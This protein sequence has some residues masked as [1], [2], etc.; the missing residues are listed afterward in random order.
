MEDAAGVLQRSVPLGLI[1]EL[2]LVG[3]VGWTPAVC[4]KLVEEGVPIVVCDR[5]G[6]ALGRFD[7]TARTAVPDRQRQ[8]RLAGDAERRVKWAREIVCG[9]IEAQRSVM[10]RIERRH[11]LVPR[12]VELERLLHATRVVE[13]LDSLRGVEGAA[14]ALYFRLRRQT[15]SRGATFAARNRDQRDVVNMSLNYVSALL[16]EKVRLAVVAA[17]L[18][19]TIGVLHESYRSRDSLVF[20]L[21]EPWR[22]Q[23]LDAT[24]FGLVGLGVLSDDSVEGEGIEAWLSVEARKRL[25]E[26]FLWRLDTLRP[27]ATGYQTSSNIF[28]RQARAFRRSLRLNAPDEIRRPH[29]RPSM[30]VLGDITGE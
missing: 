10:R 25:A 17:G 3:S 18:D 15:L 11:E 14:S 22:P 16:R 8:L 5:L 1:S 30:R 12:S 24:V 19:P 9:K 23:L 6:R 21:M 13:T 7:T 20:D 26:R 27:A 2:I 4:A 28:H 29:Q